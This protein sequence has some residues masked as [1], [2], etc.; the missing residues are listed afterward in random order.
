MKKILLSSLFLSGAVG[1]GQAIFQGNF[2]SPPRTA[3]DVSTLSKGNYLVSV[4]TKEA[5][6]T[7]NFVVE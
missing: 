2:K 3:L 5:S 4:A 6:Y 1:F 7:K